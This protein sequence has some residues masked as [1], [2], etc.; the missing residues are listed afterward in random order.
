V[1]TLQVSE[2]RAQ[3]REELIA[4]VQ[5]WAASVRFWKSPGLWDAP[6]TER[7]RKAE[8][9]KERRDKWANVLRRFVRN[10]GV[11]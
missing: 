1:T 8:E 10:Q 7:A 6:E 5:Y 4:A 3:Q 9:C 2:L 11:A